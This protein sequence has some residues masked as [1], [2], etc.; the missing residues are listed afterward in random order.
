MVPSG[1]NEETK[2][3]DGDS[4][5]VIAALD[6]VRS[7]FINDDGVGGVEFN[8]IVRFDDGVGKADV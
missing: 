4:N 6:R 2:E 8:F 1:V 7:L 5:V 3:A